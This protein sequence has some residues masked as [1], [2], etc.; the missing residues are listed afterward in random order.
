MENYFI[1]LQLILIFLTCYILG[2][3]F[4]FRIKEQKKWKWFLLS[5]LIWL[6]IFINILFLCKREEPTDITTFKGAF[7]VS[8]YLSLY[9]PVHHILA[10]ISIFKILRYNKKNANN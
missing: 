9:I 3:I 1:L 4:C 8:L 6:F 2:Y 10:L 7:F 5:W